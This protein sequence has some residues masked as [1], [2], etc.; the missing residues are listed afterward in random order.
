MAYALRYYKDIPQQ[1]GGAFRLEIYKKD[2]TSAAVEIGAIIQSLSLQIQGQQ[3]DVDAPIVKT[4]LSMTFID[5]QDLENGKKNGFWE[6]FY[7]PDAVL[8]KVILKAK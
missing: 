7:T 1:N 2:S 6:E 8:W 3:S 4:S 5:A